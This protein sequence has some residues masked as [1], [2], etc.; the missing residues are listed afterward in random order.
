MKNKKIIKLIFFTFFF[1]FIGAYLIEKTGYY[2]YNLQR[3]KNL[4]QEQMKRFEKDIQKGNDIDLNDY[5]ESTSVDYSNLLTRTTTDISL[6][7]NKTLKT[8]LKYGFKIVE[9][10]VK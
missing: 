2:E 8:F 3:K 1:A 6:K 9:K 4:T 7:L 10:F 5:L